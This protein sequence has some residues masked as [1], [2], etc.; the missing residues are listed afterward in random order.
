VLD[1]TGKGGGKER[2]LDD[3][4]VVDAW[5]YIGRARSH[6]QAVTGIAFSTPAALARGLA[7]Y[8]GSPVIPGVEAGAAAWEALPGML[9]AENP[10]KSNPPAATVQAV[11]KLHTQHNISLLASVGADRRVVLYDVGGSSVSAGLLVAARTRIESGSAIP[12]SCLWLPHEAGHPLAGIA[13][14]TRPP[15]ASAEYLDAFPVL[16]VATDAQ[17]LKIVWPTAAESSSSSDVG[18]NPASAEIRCT[19]LAPDYGGAITHML[20]VPS[21]RR[22]HSRLSAG[23]D[24]K[25]GE[26]QSNREE[27]IAVITY[28][29]DDR[30]VGVLPLPLTGTPHAYVGVVA[31]PG[32][33]N[34]LAVSDDGSQIFS[35]GI[36][37][38]RSATGSVS[39]HAA[40]SAEAEPG[41]SGSG[42]EAEAAG[43]GSVCIW[44]LERA[45]LASVAFQDPAV[46]AADE[47]E[48]AIQKNERVL[49]LLEGGKEG[50]LYASICDM[51]AY[52]QVW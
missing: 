35:C 18:T 22:S 7:E 11:L 9:T 19:V 25:E 20:S 49:E 29:T 34:G 16:M 33:V 48:A 26:P 1:A 40:A 31:H 37:Q 8:Y 27:D 50:P 28:A 13:F 39:A 47:V 32:P 12:T 5:A 6:S 52:A 3:V 17:K 51:F 2:K 23:E 30:V 41:A 4:V 10:S 21:N 24:H 42:A 44:R 43:N 45:G 14:T 36:E 15:V 38:D 46:A